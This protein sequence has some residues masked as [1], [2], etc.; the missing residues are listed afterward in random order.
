MRNLRKAIDEDKVEDFL[1]QFLKDYYCNEE[2]PNWVRDAADY[3]GY[4]ID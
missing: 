2:I 1:R 3:M 4:K